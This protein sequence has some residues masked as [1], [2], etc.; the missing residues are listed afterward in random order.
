MRIAVNHIIPG[1]G[2]SIANNIIQKINWIIVGIIAVS[3]MATIAI[4]R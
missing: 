4:I 2:Y 1:S 3:N